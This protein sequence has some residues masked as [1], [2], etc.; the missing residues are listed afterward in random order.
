MVRIYSIKLIKAL[1]N[2]IDSNNVQSIKNYKNYSDFTRYGLISGG[3]SMTFA[4]TDTR[5]EVIMHLS[6]FITSEYV[7]Q[8]RSETSA[9]K[10]IIKDY[11][12]QRKDDLD[13]SLYSKIIYSVNNQQY[14]ALLR[15]LIEIQDPNLSEIDKETYI[16]GFA[17][18]TINDKVYSIIKIEPNDDTDKWIHKDDNCKLK[19]EQPIYE[20]VV[21][22]YRTT[23]TPESIE[24]TAN[25]NTTPL[26]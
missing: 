8:W 11:K 18:I 15:L 4:D 1:Q 10:F 7:K 23:V 2:A 9:G 21:D 24:E 12:K 3:I 5:H 26:F 25:K 6:S 20:D 16:E 17:D 13:N 14:K 19:I 22:N